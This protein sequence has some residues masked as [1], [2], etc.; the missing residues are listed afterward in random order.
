MK[1]L[2]LFTCLA[3]QLFAISPYNLEGL[4]AVNIKISD[5]GKL[6]SKDKKVELKKR[7][8]D[9]ST[10]LGIKVSND[11]FSNLIIKIE[12][13]KLNTKYVLNVSLYVVENVNP[14]RNKKL[15]GLG[16]TYMSNDMFEVE[17]DLEKEIDISIFKL[18]F[19]DFKKQYQEEN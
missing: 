6:L 19:D 7:L 16:V 14:S 11:E 17:D 15:Q 2:I 9:E 10:K 13:V 3:L 12:S 5:K 18:L 4:K 1:I 8:E